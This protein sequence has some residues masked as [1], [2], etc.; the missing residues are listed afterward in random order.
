MKKLLATLLSA[1]L[2]ASPLSVFASTQMIMGEINTLNENNA[3]LNIQGTLVSKSDGGPFTT[4]PVAGTLSNLYYARD[5]APGGAVTV[6]PTVKVNNAATALTCTVTS[7]NQ[8]CSDTSDVINVNVGDSVNVNTQ[9]SG[10]PRGS[11]KSFSMVF[12]PTNPNDT[13]FFAMAPNNQAYATTSFNWYAAVSQPAET[14]AQQVLPEAGKLDTFYASSSSLV[15]GSDDLFVFQNGATSSITCTIGTP[16]FRFCS[17]TTH[18]LT[19][20]Q[21]DTF[22]LRISP[23]SA[24]QPLLAAGIRFVP[25]TAGDFDLMYNS[26]LSNDFTAGSVRYFPVVGSRTSN[27]TNEAS[28]TAI[29]SMATTFTSMSLVRAN[30]PGNAHTIIYSLRVNNATSSLTCSLTGFGSGAGFTTNTCTGSVSVL[31]GDLIDFD[32]ASAAAS[33]GTIK[34]GLVGIATGTTH[35][36]PFSYIL[37][38]IGARLKIIGATLRII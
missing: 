22:S 37:Q 24:A 32:T 1:L 3:S 33:G 27:T 5:A 15:S 38:L 36:S 31:P 30:S 11:V 34:I 7:G 16:S 18:S 21:G 13:V 28:T 9:R 29:V 10:T 35:A 8:T 6:T 20:A 26:A 4:F 12:T 14:N 2:L 17:D 23:N 19:I 25:T